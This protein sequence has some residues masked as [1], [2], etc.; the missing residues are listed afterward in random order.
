MTQQ[1][2]VQKVKQI[3]GLVGIHAPQ[4]TPLVRG[5]T[6]TAYRVD[7]DRN[8]F[9]VRFIPAAANRPVTYGSEFT[10]L[11]LLQANGVP[12]PKPI[13]TS[14]EVQMALSISEPWAVTST[15]PGRPIRHRPLSTAMAGQ[16]AAFLQVLHALPVSQFGRL[17]EDASRLCGQQLNLVAGL[18]ARWCWAPLWPL[19]GSDLRTH[20]LVNYAP[21]LFAQL[22]A[23]QQRLAEVV[24]EDQ[25]VL[26]HSDLHGEHIFV[27]GDT[28]TGIIDFGAAAICTPAW[29]F[30]VI[31]SYHGWQSCQAVLHC[32]ADEIEY[33]QLLLQ[34]RKA[35]VLVALY[36]GAKAI[37]ASADHAKIDKIILFLKNVLHEL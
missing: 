34:T 6:S 27:D 3:A 2:E 29:D 10:V 8:S 5:A 13:L 33:Q 31:A 12:V 37:N 1:N 15:V 24:T 22:S 19:D 21:T 35:A 28:I 23:M 32:Y 20:P 7:D 11:R 4:I 36:K 14:A 18:C 9:V 17:C 16:L 30:A 26:T 25:A